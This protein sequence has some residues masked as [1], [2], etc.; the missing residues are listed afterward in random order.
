MSERAPAGRWPNGARVAVMISVDHDADL[1]ILSGSPTT[2][3]RGKTLSVGRYGTDR[4]IDRL[5]GLF[6]DLR[7]PTT[8][9]VPGR[10]AER[11]PEAVR[12][13]A[14][15]GHE[16]ACHGDAHENFL[17]LTL[18]EQ[19]RAVRDAAER[20][21]RVTGAAPRGFRTPAGEWKPGLGAR[22]ADL[23]IRWSSSMPGDDLPY[24][25]PEASGLVEIPVHYELEDHQYFF[26][27]LEP[28]FPTGQSRIASYAHALDNW[29]REFIAYH[30]FGLCYVLRL[31]PE[32]TGTP[33]RIGLVREIIEYIQGCQDVWLATGSQI[34]DRWRTQ[35][36]ENEPGHPADLF[37]RLRAE[38][39]QAR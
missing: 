29:K 8:W 10:N 9:F 37:Q 6:T 7:V 22:L 17:E 18:G 19:V 3:D 1:A 24:L 4:G 32:V 20:L 39:E 27:N 12:R 35:H 21:R 5:L 14:A 13:I 26:F 2:A 33:G 25:H 31:Q 36:R 28:P 34:A 11:H 15:A 16:I 30:R 23:G 38:Q